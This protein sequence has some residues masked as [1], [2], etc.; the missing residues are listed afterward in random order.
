MD[1]PYR[2]L[3]EYVDLELNEKTVKEV[4]ERLTIAGAEV[5][6]YRYVQPPAGLRV[7]QLE[8]VKPHPEADGLSTCLV[9]MG[10][11][12]EER[13][14]ICGADNVSPGK[15]VPVVPPGGFLPGL[16]EIEARAFRGVTSEGMICSKE[17]LGLEEK[18]AGIW[19]LDGDGLSP[20]DDL[21]D[22]LEYDDYVLSFDLTSNRPDLM[23]VRGVAR[24]LAAIYGEE[25]K[26]TQIDFGLPEKE[27]KTEIILEDPVDV[28]RYSCRTLSGVEIAPSPLKIQHRL[29]KAGFRPKNNVVDATNYVLAELGQPLHPFDFSQIKG[30]KIHVR[31]A[32][33]GERLTTID[34][35]R[36]ELDEDNL[37][38]AD[39]EEPIALAGVMGGQKSEVKADS[40]NILLESACF[41][42]STVRRSAKKVAMS[43]DASRHFERGTDPEV[44]VE[45]L[46]RVVNLLDQEG[47]LSQV[48]SPT[49][50]YPCPSSPEPIRLR[51]ER[52]ESIV[53]LDLPREEIE[54]ALTSLEFEVEEG[55]KGIHYAKPPSFRPDVER[56]IDLIEEVA[57]IYGYDK[58]E[59]EPPA[60]GEVKLLEDELERAK[61]QAKE[62]LRGLGL[63]EAITTGFASEADL[64]ERGKVKFINPMGQ[65]RAALRNDLVSGLLEVAQ[66]NYQEGVDSLRLFEL[67]RYFRPEEDGAEEK[68]GL[69]LLLAGR[70]YQGIDGKATYDF[71]DIKGICLDF[72]TGM[73]FERLSFQG[74]GPSYLHPGRKAT[75]SCKEGKLGYM[76]ELH[77]GRTD[78]FDLPE[79]V[80]LAQLDFDLIARSSGED[81]SLE[82]I[83][84]YPPSKR[85]LSLVAPKE[86]EER[87]I[88]SIIEEEEMVEKT[89]LY[90][91]YE[92]E[93]LEEGRIS[94]TYEVTFRGE[95]GTLR[96]QKVEEIV[97]RLKGKLKNKGVI[98]R[99]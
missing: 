60:P 56:E 47:V 66:Y 34:G 21:M 97:D 81:Y 78:S 82:P 87:Q 41:N 40:E 93:Q 27:A 84:K 10:G 85:D 6:G 63:F 45:A 15:L 25:L 59:P 51:K 43:T 18:S 68:S 96:D 32:E 50:E 65:K 79:R 72:L 86:R 37:L 22:Q 69:G 16:G 31:R 55:K 49:D 53:G 8:E 5:E 26:E 90:D 83:P 46:D 89:F 73:G 88:R 13:T 74:D 12:E 61:V 94:L 95:E 33:K 38:I 57:R 39:Q 11:T 14:I 36:L 70:R 20:G 77:P 9:N 62:T 48:S 29:I 58:I 24:E 7:G 42:S 35:E 91:I 92:G 30:G 23:S 64:G 75:V 54:E 19:L 28:P 80:Y 17:E 67:G 2:W 52:A 71:W 4:A 44:T 99:E 76:G 3:L 98:F 1:I